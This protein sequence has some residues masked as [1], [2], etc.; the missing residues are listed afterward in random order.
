MFGSACGLN[1]ATTPA[2]MILLSMEF[3]ATHWLLTPRMNQLAGRRMAVYRVFGGRPSPV[4]RF[5]DLMDEEDDNDSPAADP[6]RESSGC[7][8]PIV[9]WRSDL[10]FPR[11]HLKGVRRVSRFSAWSES[12]MEH[13]AIRKGR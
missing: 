13:V 5:D 3:G 8:G 2:L 9:R 10:P 12:Q 11:M 6:P 4:C 7:C 1:R